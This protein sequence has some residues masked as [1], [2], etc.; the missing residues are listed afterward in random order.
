MSALSFVLF[1]GHGHLKN[2]AAQRPHLHAAHA[3]LQQALFLVEVQI[4]V[5]EVSDLT[6]LVGAQ[7][8]VLHLRQNAQQLV[9]FASGGV[10]TG[11]ALELLRSDN[12]TVLF[13]YGFSQ[14]SVRQALAPLTV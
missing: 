9:L 5:S 14:F 12:L 10:R 6:A 4:E 8:I 13:Y 3:G 7:V 11:L 1:L 2:N